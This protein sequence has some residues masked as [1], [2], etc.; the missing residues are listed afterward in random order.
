VID[1]IIGYFGPISKV[2]VNILVKNINAI[3]EFENPASSKSYFTKFLSME[4]SSKG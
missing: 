4:I 2:A 1:T 3:F